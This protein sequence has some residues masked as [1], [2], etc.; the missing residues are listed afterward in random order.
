MAKESPAGLA[1][2]DP[3]GALPRP[4]NATLCGLLLVESLKLSVAL[5]GPDAVGPN[6]MVAVQELDAARVVPQDLLKM[7]KSPGLA[8]LIVMP[9]MVMA[10]EPALVSVTTLGPPLLPMATDAHD[11]LAGD[12]DALPE[13]ANPVPES[14]TVWGLLVAA[15]VRL[16]VA[17]RVPVAVGV[18][19]M[20]IEQFADAARLAPQVVPETEKSAGL[21]PATEMLVME[22]AVAKPL[23][24]VTDWAVL[25]EPVVVPAK[26]RLDGPADTLPA[27]AAPSPLSATACGLLVSESV[28][29]RVA[30]RVPGAVGP[31][32]TLAVQLA[33]AASVVPQVLLKTEKSPGLAPA[34]VMPLI[35]MAAAPPLVRVTTF[36]PPLFP[37]ATVAHERLAGAA[38]E[39]ARQFT[40]ESAHNPSA[41][42]RPA[43]KPRVPVDFR[44]M[45]DGLHTASGRRAAAKIAT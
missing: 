33:A 25:P 23:E 4:D 16:R 40:P 32:T 3:V 6:T 37:T 26:V 8:P 15:S 5:R 34:M 19:T 31:K 44:L 10:V 7:E 13:G 41:T 24:S 39:A 38:V 1:V 36:W 12:A 14:A 27:A 42:R 30:L 17:A 20:L 43:N 2:T 28:K 11:R 29:L 45:K 9:F 21:A 18:K 22:T 35:V